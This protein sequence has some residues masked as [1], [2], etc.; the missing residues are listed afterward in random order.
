MLPVGRA[1]GLR[2]ASVM[3]RPAAPRSSVRSRSKNAA[4]QRRHRPAVSTRSPPG[5]R[6]DRSRAGRRNDEGADRRGEP[7][8]SCGACRAAG[9]IRLRHRRSS[10][11]EGGSGSSSASVVTHRDR[12]RADICPTVV[13][14]SCHHCRAMDL[15]QLAALVAVADARQ[16]LGRR[17][18]PAHRA[19]QRLDPR[20]PARARAGRHP[21]R[22]HAPARSPRRAR[23]WSAGPAASSTSSTRCV[24]TSPRCCDEVSG[25]GPP[26]RASAP[27]A[28]GS[29]RCLLERDGRAPPAGPGRGGR[30]H[31][32][33]ARPPARRRPP[34]PRRRQPAVDDPDARR[35]SRCSTRT[36]SSSR[37]PT[38]RS[39]SR[40]PVT[41]AELAEHPL[42]LEPQGTAF[43]DDLDVDAARARRRAATPGRGRRHAA[44]GLAGLRGL[45]RRRAAG[46]GRARAGTA[47]RW[48]RVAVDGRHAAVGRASPPPARAAR[49]PRPAPSRD[50]LRDLVAGPT[51]RQSTRRRCRPRRPP[52]D[53]GHRYDRTGLD[54]RPAEEHAAVPESITI[55]DNRT[56]RVGRDPDRRRRRRRR[57][58]GA[59]CCRNV[60]FYDPAS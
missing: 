27:P 13:G 47:G 16:L 50:V 12:S 40:E 32:H 58:S 51:G 28:A 56:R 7:V 31:H 2:S 46:H 4:R 43:R 11:P 60:W 5:E 37:P 20:R 34:R 21:G 22:P 54:R 57:P 48:R 8:G 38:T 26:R 3:H 44:A 24:P 18:G 39:A 45:R 17:P 36:A 52:V 9:G 23:S 35:P 30:R 33:V 10:G 25:H 29:C 14:D 41:L 15:R 55:T 49:R 59:S 6:R 19:V 1:A 42:L 53:V